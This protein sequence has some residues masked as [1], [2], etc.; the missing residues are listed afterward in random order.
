M[1]DV[2]ELYSTKRTAR[3]KKMRN[4]F[5]IML[6]TVKKKGKPRVHMMYPGEFTRYEVAAI[7]GITVQWAYLET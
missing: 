4:V 5:G 1:D 2:A 3:P 6:S 7:G